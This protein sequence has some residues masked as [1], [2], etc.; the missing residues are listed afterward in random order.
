[1]TSN[2]K[3]LAAATALAATLSGAAIAGFALS[4][5]SPANAADSV[6]KP[7]AAAHQGGA[8][9]KHASAPHKTAPS[10]STAKTTSKAGHVQVVKAGEHVTIAPGAELWLEKDGIHWTEGDTGERVI[11]VVDGNIDRSVPGVQN[12]LTSI[13]SHGDSDGA[14]FRLRM[15]NGGVKD[16]SDLSA[17][18]GFVSPLP[19][20]AD[21][22]IVMLS[23]NPGWG[24]WF[25][26][27]SGA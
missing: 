10:K 9:K 18:E 24:V 21:G 15:F 8:A 5:G 6:K 22:T 13:V 17:L 3:K 11:S 26:V 27:V 7:A 2:T 14:T 12:Q 20:P 25:D 19:D 23:G 1:M 4:G 16:A